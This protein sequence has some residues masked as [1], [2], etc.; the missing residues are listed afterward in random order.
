[1][2]QLYE[3]AVRLFVAALET[4]F[5]AG[6]VFA[7][8][9]LGFGVD[10]VDPTAKHASI[11]FRVVIAPGVALLW[12][13]LLRRWISGAPARVERNPHREAAGARA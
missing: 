8:V 2:A 1:M 10:R 12:P 11:A 3:A 13:M 4:Y 6:A 7:A 5:G 9:F